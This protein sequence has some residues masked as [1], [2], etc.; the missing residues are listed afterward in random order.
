MTDV[1]IDGRARRRE[2]VN[3]T[4]A[5]FARAFRPV[6]SP[7]ASLLSMCDNPQCAIMSAPQPPVY[8]R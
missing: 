4:E 1:A 5:P 7:A 2:P 8:F 6:S 3:L